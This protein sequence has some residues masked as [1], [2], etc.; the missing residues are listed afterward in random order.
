[1]GHFT[2]VFSCVIENKHYCDKFYSSHEWKKGTEVLI[3]HN[4]ENPAEAC[5]CDEGKS[6]ESLMIPVVESIFEA[7]MS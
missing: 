5:V 4:P 6:H 7:L 3:L 1:M 2:V